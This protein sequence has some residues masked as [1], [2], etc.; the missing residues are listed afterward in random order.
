MNCGPTSKAIA[1]GMIGNV[2]EWYAPAYLIMVAAAISFLAAL[3]M[4][5]TYRMPLA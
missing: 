2:L 3:C 5:E 4:K 1:A